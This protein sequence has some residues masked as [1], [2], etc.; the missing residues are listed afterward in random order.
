MN[1]NSHLRGKTRRQ[2][3]SGLQRKGGIIS[4]TEDFAGRDEE[5]KIEEKIRSMTADTQVPDKLQPEAVEKMLAAN[6][7]VRRRREMWKYTGATVAACLCLAVGITAGYGAFCPE[8]GRGTDA[9]QNS[10]VMAEKGEE[11]APVEG[12]SG[13]ACAGDYDEIYG[14]IRA[15]ALN[16]WWDNSNYGA[17]VEDAETS[18]A[19]GNDMAAKSST[20]AGSRS[21]AEHSDTNVREEGVGEGDIVKTDGEY[22]YVMTDRKI[23]IV[24]IG[25]AD[26]EKTAAI[27]L[28]GEG[29]FSE[30]YVEGDILAAVYTE[31]AQEYGVEEDADA[32]GR[33]CT[34]TGVYVYDISDAAQPEQVGVFS[35]SGYFNTMRVKDGYVYLIS[36]FYAGIPA[37]PADREA[38]IP[39]VQE[40][41]LAPEDI[42]IPAGQSGKEYTLISAFALNA[43][44]EETDT[45][46]VLGSSSRC[47]VSGENIYVAEGLC[48]GEEGVTRTCVRKIAYRNGGLAAKAQAEVDGTLHDSFSID[49]YKGYLRLVTTV[50][51]VY[52]SGGGVQPIAGTARTEED[53]GQTQLFQADSN[54]LYVLDQDLEVVGEIHDLAPGESVYSARFMGDTGYFVTFEE[55]DPLFSV[56]LSDPSNP[57]IIGELKLPGFSEYLHPYG[58]GRLLGIGMDVDEESITTEGVK[59]SMFDISDPASV[60]ETAFYVIEDMYGTDVAY[61]YRAVFVDTEKN[62]FGFTAW[63]S[64]ANWYYIFTFDE[65]GFHEVLKRELSGWGETRGLYAGERFYIVCGNTVE[66]YTM[67]GFEK[68]DDIVL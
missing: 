26:M 21:G 3:Q 23:D 20:D 68:V 48:D 57:E 15:D 59:L 13:L 47:Y 9:G 49:E 38:Y 28:E 43:P 16:S 5:E 14:Y 2:E 52:T 54:S 29:W 34:V 58:E 35:Q 6:Q 62:L 65:T 39:Q 61:N 33:D 55:V 36:N 7:H 46:A 56:N 25:N 53:A 63:S 67:D 4:G 22:L 40:K 64:G 12:T 17:A 41:L 45:A 19:M 18:A 11:E 66:S 32:D 1:L 30:L 44:E 42:Y 37:E 50:E 60:Q 31:S 10:A 51:P 24:A 27:T 8:D